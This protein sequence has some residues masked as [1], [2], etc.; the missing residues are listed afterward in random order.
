[1]VGYGS[2]VTDIIPV[3]NSIKSLHIQLHKIVKNRSH[4]PSDEAATKL[5]FWL[6]DRLPLN[7]IR[8]IS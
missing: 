7:V 4:F 5:L 3:I 8:Y 2:G 6:S 1:M